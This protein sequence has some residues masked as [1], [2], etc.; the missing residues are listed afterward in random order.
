M[1]AHPKQLVGLLAKYKAEFEPSCLGV[2]GSN[3]CD[4]LACLFAQCSYDLLPRD[5]YSD[6]LITTNSKKRE[7][8]KKGS[9][10]EHYDYGFH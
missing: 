1:F 2:L 7:R 3:L 10:Y 8:K 9:P 5:G 6:C 4:A